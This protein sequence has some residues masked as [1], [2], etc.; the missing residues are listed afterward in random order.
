M[1]VGALAAWTGGEILAGGVMLLAVG[2]FVYYAMALYAAGRF[3]RRE[4]RRA[5]PPA[6]FAPPV[7][8]LKPVRGLDR[9]SYEN[10]ASF[11]R[12]DYPA[13]EIL[14]CAS[15]AADPAIPV[16]EQLI[17]DFPQVPIRLLVGA[18]P[19][20]ANDRTNKVIRLVREAR[21]DIL[22]VTNSNVRVAPDYLRR[23]AAAFADSEVGAAS[24]VFRSDAPATLVGRLDAIGSCADFWTSALVAVWLE[25]GP[26]FFHGATVAL[27]R[28]SLEEIGG[29]EAVA[30]H[31]TEDYL[32]GK[33]LAERGH[34]V[35]LLATP[36]SLVLADYTLRGYW[37]HEMLRHVRLRHIRPRG[38][39]G[40]LFTHGLPWTIL[41]AAVA[42]AAWI[43]A[44]YAGAY[45]ALRY[46]S[47]AAVGVGVLSDATVRRWWWL[48]P[49]RD[50]LAFALWLGSYPVR[51][52]RWRGLDFRI[53]QD[54]QLVRDSRPAGAVDDFSPNR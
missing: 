24:I 46:A 25:G 45:L 54:G 39:F 42:P 12:Q 4:R 10:F 23:L 17:R 44:A 48:A 13:Y 26:K 41:A 37:K 1:I 18:E 5:A 3:L 31:A 53:D 29:F 2:P 36:F 7:S 35:T 50:A 9:N 16:V 40:M 52:F 34:R 47:L 32:L 19:L 51:R 28:S 38:Y 33:R 20:G 6:D 27:R 22:V 43:S 14:F 11:C 49:L 21:H 15:D 30:D 8:V